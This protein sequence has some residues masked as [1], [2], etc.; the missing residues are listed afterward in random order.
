MVDRSSRGRF[1]Y[2]FHCRPFLASVSSGEEC[3]T[4]ALKGRCQNQLKRRQAGPE[5]LFS[6][7]RLAG[8]TPRVGTGGGRL[9]GRAI[10]GLCEVHFLPLV[11]AVGDSNRT[12]RLQCVGRCENPTVKSFRTNVWFLRFIAVICCCVYVFCFLFLFSFCL[13]CYHLGPCRPKRG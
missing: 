5:R 12:Q 3:L 4:L 11:V 9:L 13:F 7:G 10:G 6:N 1:P 2:H 8:G